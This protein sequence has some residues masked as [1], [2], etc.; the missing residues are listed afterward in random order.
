[1]PHFNFF[2]SKNK[3]KKLLLSFLHIWIHGSELDIYLVANCMNEVVKGI[4]VASLELRYI[5]TYS[6]WFH[7]VMLNE[8]MFFDW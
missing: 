2:F 3:K 4:D 5:Q 7:I 1:M 6:C 8:V